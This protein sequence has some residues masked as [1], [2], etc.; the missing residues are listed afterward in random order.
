[1]PDSALSARLLREY[2]AA[3]APQRER[4]IATVNLTY[5]AALLLGSALLQERPAGA[6]G[7]W[8]AIFW[9]VACLALATA[10]FAGL[11]ISTRRGHYRPWMTTA[12][13]VLEVAVPLL[14]MLAGVLTC[15]AALVGW[16]SARGPR[17]V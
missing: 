11:L 6:E 1:M 3:Q 2:I 14:V 7:H 13:A 9:P 10:G 4:A 12:S 16:C 5:S 15:V 17:P 8:F